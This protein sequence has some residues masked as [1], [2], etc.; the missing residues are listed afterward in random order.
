MT[1]CF[2]GSVFNRS[3]TTPAPV[4]KSDIDDSI[5]NLGWFQDYATKW[6]QTADETFKHQ[7]GFNSAVNQSLDQLTRRLNAAGIPA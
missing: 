7:D 4:L 5:K 6:I 2:T 3:R 1:D